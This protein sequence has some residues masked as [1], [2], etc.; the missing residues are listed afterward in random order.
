MI[1]LRL[2]A[3]A[4]LLLWPLRANALIALDGSCSATATGTSVSCSITTAV[5]NDIIIAAFV[6]DSSANAVSVTATGLTFV[7]QYNYAYGAGQRIYVYYAIAASTQ[8]AKS[9]TANVTKSAS[10][11]LVVFGASGGDTATPFD[12]NGALPANANGTTGVATV[13]GVSTTCANTMLVGVDGLNTAILPPD[14][15]GSGY[16]LI[17]ATSTAAFGANASAEYK[18]VSAA[19]SSVT[20]AFGTDTTSSDWAISAFALR[21]ASCAPAASGAKLLRLLGV[22][23]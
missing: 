8:S 16:T 12:T 17:Q 14:T 3:L 4:F 11:G 7:V 13:S 10:I 18:V 19:Q 2:F 1:R 21:A 5:T 6:V 23:Q 9:V 20:T 15:A 22:G